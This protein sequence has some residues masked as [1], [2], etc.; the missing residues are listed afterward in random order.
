MR[1]WVEEIYWC[2][3]KV[4]WS[5][6]LSW[7]MFGISSSNPKASSNAMRLSIIVFMDCGNRSREMS[8]TFEKFKVVYWGLSWLWNFNPN[9]THCK[10]VKL[11]HKLKEIVCIVKEEVLHKLCNDWDKTL[12]ASLTIGGC[13]IANRLMNF[14]WVSQYS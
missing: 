2:Q 13:S 10:F 1:Q 6:L 8:P 4:A 14:A 7:L 12:G 9:L 5:P 11:D 3:G